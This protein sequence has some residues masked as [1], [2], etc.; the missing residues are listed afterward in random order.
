VKISARCTHFL[1]CIVWRE[2]STEELS[3]FKLNTVTYGT[4][5]VAFLAIRAMHQLSYD[6]EES[7]PIGAKI[8]RRDFYV[9][10]L[11][12]GGDSVEEVRE[13]RRQVKEL[14][15]RGHFPMRKWCSNESGRRV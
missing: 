5:P 10:D 12:S 8:V 14:L 4:K 15:S 13:I 6:E 7:F 3:V 1:Q 2:S 11:I 9:D